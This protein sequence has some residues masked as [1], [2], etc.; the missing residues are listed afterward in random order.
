MSKRK[1]INKPHP[2]S[3]AS[4]HQNQYTDAERAE[5]LIKLAVNKHNI[6]QTAKELDIPVSTLRRWATTGTKKGVFPLLERAIERMLMVIPEKWSGNE[7]AIAL[8]ILIDKFQ[9]MQGEPTSRTEQLFKTYEAL[10]EDER[11]Y[12]S[13]EARRLIEEVGSG[14][15]GGDAG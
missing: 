10:T 7:W 3:T 12:V 9:L 15:T 11:A 5:A 4:R 13:A 1:K 14:N 2:K 8:G 6:R